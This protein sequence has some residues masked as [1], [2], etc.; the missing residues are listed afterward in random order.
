MIIK[1]LIFKIYKKI[2][3]Y[4]KNKKEKEEVSHD[5]EEFKRKEYIYNKAMISKSRESWPGG[6]MT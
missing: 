1:K 4:L 6:P 3:I 2:V 5:E